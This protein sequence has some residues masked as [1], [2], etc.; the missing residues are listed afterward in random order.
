MQQTRVLATLDLTDALCQKIET[1]IPDVKLQ[2]LP[3]RLRRATGFGDPKT[4]AGWGRH[5]QEAH[6]LFT[7]LAVPRGLA[8]FARNLRMIHVASAGIETLPEVDLF[9][10][11]AI[12]ISIAVGGAN[13]TAVAEFALSSMLALSKGLPRL[14]AHQRRRR[15]L[16]DHQP[17]LLAGKTL[18]LVGLGHINRDLARMA[19]ALSMRVVGCSRT[20]AAGD[21]QDFV[22]EVFPVGALRQRLGEGDFVV[23]TVPL[24]PETR[25]MIGRA[26]LA[27]MRPTAY[28]VNVGRGMLV[29]EEAL[30]R[31]LRDGEIA[32]AA[33]DVFEEEPLPRSSPLWAMPNVVIS[34]HVAGLSEVFLEGVVDQ[35]CRNLQRLVAGEPLLNLAHRNR[36]Y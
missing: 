14:L 33:L 32:G 12:P 21:R 7:D 5:L 30:L 31:A 18:I 2:F 8:P 17:R 34:P 25:G 29:Q 36:G 6:V 27:A 11:T 4:V 1:A 9:R 20:A 3:K 15:W 23:V 22:D 16:H 24:T 10:D 19:K 28:L 26:E 13:S 35:L